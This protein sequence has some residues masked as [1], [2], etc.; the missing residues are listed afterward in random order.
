MTQ[1]ILG[2]VSKLE[3]GIKQRIWLQTEYGEVWES[4]GGDTA[5][6][7]TDDIAEHILRA[8]VLSAASTWTNRAI[9]QYQGE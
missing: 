5:P 8:Y 9:L 7:S 1:L 2:Q 6:H 4:D 3:V